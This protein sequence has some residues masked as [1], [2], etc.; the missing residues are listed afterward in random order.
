MLGLRH[1]PVTRIRKGKLN[2][3]VCVYPPHCA[4]VPL[5]NDTSEH[6]DLYC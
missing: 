3:T 2:V 1:A 4:D 6:F 5:R